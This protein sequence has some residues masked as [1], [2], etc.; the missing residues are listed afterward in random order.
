MDFQPLTIG[1]ERR[2]LQ[3]RDGTQDGNKPHGR[4]ELEASRR[5]RVAGPTSP[6]CLYG[7]VLPSGPAFIAC[8]DLYNI[9]NLL[10]RIHTSNDKPEL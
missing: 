9:F 6:S 1:W 10:C 3:V 4:K 5:R 8:Y 2:L 7:E